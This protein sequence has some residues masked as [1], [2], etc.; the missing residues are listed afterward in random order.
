MIAPDLGGDAEADES[1]FEATRNELVPFWR[2]VALLVFLG[3]I[4]TLLSLILGSGMYANVL[5]EGPQALICLVFAIYLARWVAASEA[6][7]AVNLGIDV[8]A[9]GG[10]AA[11]VAFATAAAGG[12][13]AGPGGAEDG[14][15]EAERSPALS[16]A[17]SVT[18]KNVFG[19]AMT[20]VTLILATLGFQR[21][22]SL[23]DS[24]FMLTFT[25]LSNP[26][27]AL[28]VWAVT[29]QKECSPWPLFIIVVVIMPWSMLALGELA[30]GGCLVGKE[31]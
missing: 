25:W 19:W 1:W 17:V 12:A 18:Q 7:R 11:G 30:D 13:E 8:G 3:V 16:S 22:F 24:S 14:E 4:G 26:L 2:V 23:Q 5:S 6:E 10:E 20:F 27:I 21:A 31:R 15:D 9:A 29:L 28:L